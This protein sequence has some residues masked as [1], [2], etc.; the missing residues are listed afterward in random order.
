[1]KKKT[2]LF[3]VILLATAAAAFKISDDIISRLGMKYRDAQMNIVNNLVG[4]F[5]TSAMDLNVEENSESRYVQMNSFKMPY[6]PLLANIIQEDKAAAAKDLCDYVK[7][8]VNSEEFITDYNKRRE[9]AMP[10]SDNGSS[11]STLKGNKIVF[12][13]NINNYKTDT[14]YV[15]E[16]QKLLEENQKRIDALIEES[17][18]PFT[19]KDIWEKAFPAEPEGLV[20]KR[21][22]E[23][24]SLVATV[25]F[26]ATLSASEGRKQ[27]TN[28]AYEKKSLKWKALYR[29]GKEVNDVV[30][31]FVKEW[32]K[33]EI[34]AKE[35]NKM[36]EKAST[37]TNINQNK[38]TQVNTS[39]A[40]TNTNQN[41]T[42]EVNTPA[43]SSTD[44]TATPVKKKKSLLNKIKDK[45][46]SVIN[47]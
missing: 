46:N 43:T 17:K 44:S 7:R 10:L 14:K 24:L 45:T 23:Y 21:L 20:K 28:P 29:A 30:T 6:V 19:G 39:E 16:Q 11:L 31:A 2:L 33:G 18:K 41:N 12:E 22:Q 40:P 35:K 8:Y 37:E 47:N 1:M 34:I 25:D 42:V 32:M 4:N 13:K 27:F 15:A 9:E 38:A 3:S 26:N 5:S 36:T